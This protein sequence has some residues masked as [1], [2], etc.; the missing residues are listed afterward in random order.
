MLGQTTVPLVGLVDTAI[1]GRT[2]DAA[3]LA[4]VAMGVAIINFVFWAFGFLRMGVTGMT[5]QA[6]GRGDVAEVSALMVRGILAGLG[7]G[8]LLFVAQVVIVPLALGLL[9]GGGA[10]DVAAHDFI[11]ARFF[12]APAAL[13]WYAIVGWL[14]GIGRTRESLVLQLVMNAANIGLDALFVWHFDW[15]ARGVGLGTSAAEWVAL[16]TGLLMIARILGRKGRVAL[17]S[18]GAVILGRAA[19]RRLLVVNG[20]IMIRTLALLA[21][22]LWM[23]NAGA[24]LGAEALSANHILMQL[25]SLV[26]FILDG[27]CFTAESRVGQAIGNGSRADLKRGMSLT[28]ELTFACGLLASL[29]S[30]AFGGYLI[31]ALTSN[32]HVRANAY[33]LLWLA[34]LAPVIGVPAWVLDGVFIGATEGRTLRN[35]ALLA[36]SLYIA[37]D[38]LLR[39]IGAQGVWIALLVSYAY[40]AIPLALAFPRVLARVG[41]QPSQSFQ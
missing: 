13:A 38:Y 6:H 7:L 14:Y 29:L 27:F 34:A 22:F 3:A 25:V 30:I 37:T 31:D 39:P 4:G 9:A 16:V 21:M 23:A 35:A 40:R 41:P 20:D 11:T 33:T 28:F 19:W 12:G 17:R 32:P 24:R 1:I 10:L 15:G 5:A 26:A 18:H 2:G 36:T 8:I